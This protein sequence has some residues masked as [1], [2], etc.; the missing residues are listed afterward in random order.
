MEEAQVPPAP[1]VT[2]RSLPETPDECDETARFSPPNPPY[3]PVAG[4]SSSPLKRSRR[5]KEESGDE[6]DEFTPQAR[7]KTRAG[8]RSKANPPKRAGSG[9]EG[10]GAK[11]DLCGMHLGRVTD[12]P[13]HK[14]S[15]KSNPERETRK[16]P[17]KVCGKLL[18]G[19]ST[20][21]LSWLPHICC[22]QSV[23]MPSSVT[24]RPKRAAP[25]GRRVTMK[26]RICRN[27][28]RFSESRGLVS[29]PKIVDWC[30]YLAF[31]SP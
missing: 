5:F 28:S 3:S 14:A 10:K 13:R 2:T 7:K 9:F 8:K 26:I 15:C 12:I 6:S 20:L 24:L 11:C 19:N 22:S 17:C 21:S 29:Y 25:N 31:R 30:Q 23:R 27:H 16:T 1:V 4:P 18:P